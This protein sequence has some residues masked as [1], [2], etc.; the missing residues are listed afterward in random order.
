MHRHMHTQIGTLGYTL[1]HM[2][3]N[4]H[5]HTQVCPDNG[6]GAPCV[7]LGAGLNWEKKERRKGMK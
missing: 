1:T 5:T 4:T 7:I 6:A 2:G 3:K